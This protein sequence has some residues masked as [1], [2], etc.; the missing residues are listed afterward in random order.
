[1]KIVS[2][3]KKVEW[4]EKS[5]GDFNAVLKLNKEEIITKCGC[6]VRQGDNLVPNFSIIVL[7]LFAEGTFHIFKTDN[8]EIP[9]ILYNTASMGFLQG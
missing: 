5:Y 8:K 4:V 6:I 9:T 1:M 3:S 2:P 7:C